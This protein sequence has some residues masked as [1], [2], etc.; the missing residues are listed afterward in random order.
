MMRSADTY[1]AQVALDV[2]ATLRSHGDDGHGFCAAG[3]LNT[4]E[5]RERYPCDIRL[6]HERAAH[7][8]QRRAAVTSGKVVQNRDQAATPYRSPRPAASDTG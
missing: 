2:E 6:W 3:C 4:F 7:L 1:R 8:L 5:N